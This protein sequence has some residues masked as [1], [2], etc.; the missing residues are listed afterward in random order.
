M[1][2]FARF[3]SEDG[4]LARLAALLLVVGPSACGGGDL[5]PGAA[6]DS[7]VR[8]QPAPDTVSAGDIGAQADGSGADRGVGRDAGLD[9]APAVEINAGW[10][11]GACSSPADCSDPN[12]GEP[13]CE[14]EAAGFPGGFCTQV[15]DGNIC[16]DTDYAGTLST[17]SRCID[18]G[19]APRCASEC[20]YAK[21]PTGCRPG[22]ACVMRARFGQPGTVFPICL[23]AALKRWPGE[24]PEDPD[25][26][27][28]CVKDGECTYGKCLKV[29]GGYCSKADCA[30]SGCP[31]GS[32]CSSVTIKFK[33]QKLCV[34]DCAGTS[35]CRQG[36]GYICVAG[37]CW[38]GPPPSWD[39][40]LATQDCQTWWGTA[41]EPL[42]KCDAVKDDYLVLRKSARNLALCAKGQLIQSFHVGLGFS[43][44]GDKQQQGDGK[45]PEGVFYIP[46]LVP[47]SKF[48]RAFLLSYPDAA[49]AAWGAQQG[50]I[51]AADKSAID[52]AQSACSEPPQSTGLGGL[53]EVHGFGALLDWTAG[54]IAIANAE[55][56]ELWS[57]LE[58]GDTIVVVP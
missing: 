37:R 8:S 40:S 45:T 54:C 4:M 58:V 18:A 6:R 25:I 16:P 27:A 42:S 1:V 11:G 36:E 3:H 24:A 32:S 41:G 28:P 23:P 20:D 19:G 44:V 38:V 53:V 21:S 52:Q 29:Q 55:I 47:S 10:I 56:D 5:A 7:G 31:L 43:P 13:I 2:T 26:G 12:I 57:V 14:K 30:T 39:D 33:T 34:K 17:T 50:V 15:C 22:Y 49:D 46:R 51:S 35:M 9:A 48:Y